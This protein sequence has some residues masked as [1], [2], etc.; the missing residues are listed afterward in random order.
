MAIPNRIG[1]PLQNCG[2]GVPVLPAPF[3]LTEGKT[4]QVIW[5]GTE[6][7][8]VCIIDPDTGLPAISDVVLDENYSPTN[9]TF[10]IAYASPEFTGAEDDAIMMIAYDLSSGD[11]LDF[12]NTSHT[13]AIYQQSASGGEGLPVITEDTTFYAVYDKELRYYTASFYVNGELQST[14]IVPYGGVAVPP[15]V[16]VEAG[17]VLQWPEDLTIYGDSVFD[18]IIT[19]DYIISGE[20]TFTYDTQDKVYAATVTA[21]K[22]P[23]YTVGA[24]YV[25]EWNGVEHTCTAYTAKGVLSG[26][27]QS[28]SSNVIGNVKHMGKIW[29]IGV[30]WTTHNS[31]NEPFVILSAGNTSNTAY[32]KTLD[33]V[34]TI[35]VNIYAKQ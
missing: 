12:V 15:D 24:T 3:V 11:I 2:D 28:V 34:G 33:N 1:L 25:V 13:V 35:S 16:T 7:T 5:D 14:Q 22:A 8:C 21:N 9:G 10:A 6:H 32:I 23:V 31:N 20:Y 29:G 4:Y 26:T 19:R 27:T 17:M 18:G 30:D